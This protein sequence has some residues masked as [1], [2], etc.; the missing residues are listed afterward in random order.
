MNFAPP[1]NRILNSSSGL[2]FHLPGK[3]KTIDLWV[4]YM[5]SYGNG[6]RH[7][8]FIFAIIL[9]AFFSKYIQ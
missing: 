4:K 5:Y 3:K 8:S 7:Q 6:T 2:F 9:D 1:G